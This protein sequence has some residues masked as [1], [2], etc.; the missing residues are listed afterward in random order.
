[1]T[2][3]F[4]FDFL[5]QFFTSLAGN[6]FLLLVAILLPCV[7]LFGFITIYALVVIYT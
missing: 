1:M 3:D 4:I 6:E 7:V 5:N 2:V